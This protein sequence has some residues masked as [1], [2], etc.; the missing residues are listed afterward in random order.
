M[1]V[2]GFGYSGCFVQKNKVIIRFCPARK[3]FRRQGDFRSH[4]VPQSQQNANAMT[5]QNATTDAIMVAGMNCLREK[6][7]VV[8]A[9]V[10]L[11]MI[12]ENTFDYTEWRRDNLWQDMSLDEIF[13]LAA[14][15]EKDRY[16]QVQR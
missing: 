6:L 7:G 13:Q 1:L 8:E 4:T 3:I 14:E 10:F 16:A 9:E 11:A 12:R 2:R 5:I 15:R